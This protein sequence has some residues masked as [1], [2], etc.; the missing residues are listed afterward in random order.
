MSTLSGVD[1]WPARSG[2]A[3]TVDIVH[4]VR[5]S[6]MHRPR[7]R[8]RWKKGGTPTLDGECDRN[9]WVLSSNHHL[10]KIPHVSECTA[11]QCLFSVVWSKMTWIS[12]WLVVVPALFSACT[13]AAAQPD[14]HPAPSSFAWLA[15][16]SS[17]GG[18]SHLNLGSNPA[19]FDCAW[20]SAAFSYAQSL[21][22]ELKCH[23]L[24]LQVMEIVRLGAP[25]A[26]HLT[27]GVSI[28]AGC[29]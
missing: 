18:T 10:L 21:Q 14:V 28:H 1:T 29:L 17:G 13:F 20:R 19:A 22:P 7:R 5:H 2:L 9:C 25:A 6:I 23:L 24:E 4:A 16:A 11:L 12:L 8:A 3:T 15:A 26:W 27:Q